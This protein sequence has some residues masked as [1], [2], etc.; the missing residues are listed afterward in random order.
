M[1]LAGPAIECTGL[2]RRYGDFLAVDAI[3][4]TVPRGAVF[5]FLGPNGAGKTTTIR[6]LLGLLTPS[7]GRVRVLDEELP[8]GGEAVRRRVGAVLEHPGFYEGLAVRRTLELHAAA[9][10]LH[11]ADAAERIDE[12]AERLRVADRLDQR[13]AALSRGLRQRLAIARALLGRPE[14]LILDEPTNGL[15]PQAAADLRDGLTVLAGTGTTVFLATHLLSEAERLCDLVA[16]VKAGRI[17]ATGSPADLQR[18]TDVRRVT[19]TGPG[20][21][22]V[23]AAALPP[24]TFEQ[25]SP[26]HVVVAVAGLDGVGDVVAALVR[27]GGAIH[28]VEPQGQSLE[29]AFLSLVAD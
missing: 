11:G 25:P 24:G 6:L 5:G 16:V 29:A 10:G 17:I 22:A 4:L 14:L 21:A 18:S 27:A 19:V 1:M 23:A 20:L 12:V 8:A 9:H 3:D 13:P 7:A 26:D 2:S 28:R 15:D